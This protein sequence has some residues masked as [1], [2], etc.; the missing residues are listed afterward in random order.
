MIINNKKVQILALVTFFFASGFI[1]INIAEAAYIQDNSVGG[2]CSLIGAWDNSTKTCA[3]TSNL[4][5]FIAI[6]GNNITLNGNNYQITGN[7]VGTGIIIDFWKNITVKN[8]K[9]KNFAN[10]VYISNSENNLITD[11]II[12]DN[13]EIGLILSNSHGNTVTENE[14][15]DNQTSGLEIWYIY[16]MSD[17]KIYRN[18]FINNG[19][20][21]YA[22][23]DEN[24]QD[25]YPWTKPNGW[26][27]FN[28]PPTFS[29]QNQYKLDG[30][31]P[32]SENGITT[33]NTAVFK[34]AVSDADG[35]DVKLEIEL[36]RTDEFGGSFINTPTASSAYAASGAT[37]T[38]AVYGLLEGQYHWQ[39]RAIDSQGNASEW[40]E[41]AIA[42]NVD[43][44]VELPLATKA[45][46]L[47][48]EL[49]YQP[50]LWGGKGW[51]YNLA[52]FVSADIIK[53][54]YDFYLGNAISSGSGVDCSGLIMWAY[55]RS[56]D[57]QKSRSNNFVKAE[58][59]DEQYRYNT[60]STTELEPKPG[61]VM[62]FDW[63][64]FDESIGRWDGIKDNYIDHM[65][66]YVGESGGYDVVSATS[67]DKGIEE[68]IKNNYE[69]L[70]GFVAFKKVI[71]A[72]DPE[73]SIKISSP[74]DL[75]VTDPDGFTITPTTTIPS[76]LEYL[77]E[78]PGQ[79]YYSEMEEGHDGY[80]ADQVYSY[81]AKTGNYII[82]VLPIFGA[83]PTATYTL[84]FSAGEQTITLAQDTPINQI[85]ING[86][87]ITTSATGTLNTFIP[88]SID[89]KPDSYPNAINL[90]SNGVVPVAIFGS[91]TFNVSQIDVSTITLANSTI[92][93]KGNGQPIVGY[94]DING[95]GFTD[96]TANIT[97]EALQLTEND[98]TANLEGRLISGE[99]IKGSDSI[100]IV[101]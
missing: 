53:T 72:L 70:S 88:V 27:P 16:L 33:E 93:L 9:I 89:I 35:D 41:F 7:N 32:I 43:F 45:A 44:I 10:G 56:F 81:T 64:K 71:S 100:R 68:K 47:A 99:I 48:K 49:V 13:S 22:F 60:T 50:Y 14:I 31:T 28:Q 8:L 96:L 86:Y 73:V 38:T 83:S 94:S 80:P 18:N 24:S 12:S 61:D 51:D 5:D 54:G 17:N 29:N 15:S 85:P 20:Q 69:G 25:N 90:S 59:A 6:N 2:D 79:L 101:P 62:F 46:N 97:T 55:N 67:K 63:G 39:A 92:K 77:R 78:I 58:G 57:S 87:G 21:I 84:D 11:N 4:N 76:D 82:K 23:F 91:P 66:M 75:A 3:L 37:S 40:Q 36:R 42:G 98:I 30:Q 34:A 1:F 52:E 65:A 19:H 74:V 26:K 95:D